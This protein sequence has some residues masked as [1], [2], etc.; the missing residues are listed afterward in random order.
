MLV[1]VAM[2]TYNGAQF[3]KQQLASI[4]CQTRIPDEI[5][6]SDDG[7][8]DETAQLVALISQSSEVPILFYE[9][10]DH[11]GYVRNFERAMRLCRGD[12][13]FLSDQD[14][15]WEPDK[16]RAILSEFDEPTLLVHSDA[17]LIDEGG[18][19]I[20]DS[21]ARLCKRDMKDA[22]FCRLLIDNTVSGCT[23]AF[24]RSLLDVMPAADHCFHHD[25]LLAL[26]AADR[27]GLRYVD[28]PLIQYRQH[29]HNIIGAG[30]SG[31][32]GKEIDITRHFSKNVSIHERRIDQYRLATV[33]LKDSVSQRSKKVMSDLLRYHESFIED[34]FPLRAGWLY[35]RY[36][37]HMDKH[38]SILRKFFKLLLM[39]FCNIRKRR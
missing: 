39:P 9:N 21:Y 3:L 33:V 7:S 20:G 26:L 35:F 8:G 13:I 4:L 24:K 31:T 22:S 25:Q 23:L 38:Y 32:D 2:A 28:R 36:F 30:L 5:I 15:I 18:K 14:D 27:D 19:V 1:S 29:R 16:T 11:L 34:L 12:I 37:R 10:D 6:V 17:R